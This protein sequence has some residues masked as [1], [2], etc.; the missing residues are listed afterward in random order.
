M[1]RFRLCSTRTPNPTARDAC[2]CRVTGW[3]N[4]CPPPAEIGGRIKRSDTTKELWVKAT[5][6]RGIGGGE[7]RVASGGYFLIS[8]LDDSAYI[9]AVMD[10]ESILHQ[11]I[12]KTYPVG[13]GS[14]KLD[15]DLSQAK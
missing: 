2:A 14:T 1:Q 5:P 15:I 11:Q 8:G 12:V 13:S 7:A 9:V 3:I 6:V 10:G 4:G